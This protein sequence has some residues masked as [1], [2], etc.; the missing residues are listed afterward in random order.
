[1]YEKLQTLETRIEK[2]Y[3]VIQEKLEEE[4]IKK[5]FLPDVENVENNTIT[6]ID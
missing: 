6:P 2:L 5:S 1:M 3:N 4:A